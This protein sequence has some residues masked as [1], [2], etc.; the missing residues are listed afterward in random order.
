[1]ITTN[2]PTFNAIC[3]KILEGDDLRLLMVTPKG[4]RTAVGMVTFDP[5]NIA[6][7]KNMR[8]MAE[9]QVEA[10]DRLILLS[11]MGAGLKATI[12]EKDDP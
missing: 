10:Y 11:E 6:A 9:A 12:I 5:A 2:N 4:S 3:D 1:M 8:Q 7:Y